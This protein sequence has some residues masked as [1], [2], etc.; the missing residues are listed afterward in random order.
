MQCNLRLLQQV[1]LLAGLR[2]QPAD[3]DGLAD[4]QTE[5]CAQQRIAE[6]LVEYPA[7]YQANQHEHPLH[8]RYP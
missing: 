4:R 2:P 1:A 7:Q 6:R 8:G 5:Q 3:A